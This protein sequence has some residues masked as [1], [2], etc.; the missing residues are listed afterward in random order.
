MG[1]QKHRNG[2]DSPQ[3]QTDSYGKV[4]DPESSGK[5]QLLCVE[6]RVLVARGPTRVF[7]KE[8]ERASQQREST[9]LVTSRDDQLRSKLCWVHVHVMVV[10][11]SHDEM[12]LSKG[13]ILGVVEEIP[14]AL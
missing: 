8:T 14:L 2:Q 10:N 11:F 4:R 5:P 3:S 9:A 12:E 1:G 7:A 13:T 6:A